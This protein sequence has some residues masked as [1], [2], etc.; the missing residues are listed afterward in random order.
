MAWR[1]RR[2]R[3]PAPALGLGL[4]LAQHLPRAH[5]HQHH[6]HHLLLLLP[7]LA[8]GLGRRDHAPRLSH[9]RSSVLA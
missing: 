6:H 3:L 2:R 9:D 8:R 5:H 4:D 1:R 7:R